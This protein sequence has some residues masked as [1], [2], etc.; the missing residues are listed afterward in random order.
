MRCF[1]LCLQSNS[2]GAARLRASFKINRKANGIGEM[3]Q[4]WRRSRPRS[5]NLEY[6]TR[7]VL[8]NYF[9]WTNQTQ[10]HRKSI[11]FHIF[12]TLCL[13]HHHWTRKSN[14]NKIVRASKCTRKNQDWFLVK[15]KSL[16]ESKNDKFG[17]RCIIVTSVVIATLETFRNNRPSIIIVSN[18]DSFLPWTKNRLKREREKEKTESNLLFSCSN[19]EQLAEF[20]ISSSSSS[21]SP[22]SIS[23][24]NKKPPFL[25]YPLRYQDVVTAIPITRDTT[26]PPPPDV[27]SK[28][29][30]KTIHDTSKRFRDA[31]RE[32]VSRCWRREIDTADM[33][34]RIFIPRYCQMFAFYCGHYT[35]FTLWF[36][37][38]EEKISLF[39]KYS[40][41]RMIYISLSLILRREQEEINLF[42]SKKGEI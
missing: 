26:I 42:N 36:R 15:I 30:R 4:Q 1:S 32:R 29:E 14:F 17:W 35:L 3:I 20:F 23:P 34:T 16:R 40:S 28:R 6:P 7:F 13:L 41:T 27:N 2:G 8:L 12:L 5:T 37:P 33:D 22:G 39:E 25:Y 19:Q 10:F 31:V 9:G 21:S 11:S 18:I 24:G 38:I